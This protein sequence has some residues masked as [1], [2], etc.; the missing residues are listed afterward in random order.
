MQRA[1]DG[2][3]IGEK[4][5]KYGL[6]KPAGL[7]ARRPGPPAAAPR[8]NIFGDD[9]SDE[10]IEAQVARQAD[11]KRSAAKVWCQINHAVLAGAMQRCMHGTQ[12]AKTCHAVSAWFWHVLVHVQVQ[13]IYEQALAEDPSVFDYDGV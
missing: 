13:Q 10:D 1:A 8:P 2:S 4:G 3:L 7:Q 9:D 12:R 5:V 11:R 6:Q